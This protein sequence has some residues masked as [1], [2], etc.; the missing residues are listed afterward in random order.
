[1]Q[2]LE[3]SWGGYE[4]QS[5]RSEGWRVGGKSDGGKA[6][7]V[8][9]TQGA[10]ADLVCKDPS[11]SGRLHLPARPF[12]RLTHIA[13]LRLVLDAPRPP[14]NF[15]KEQNNRQ[16]SGGKKSPPS[17]KSQQ[18]SS[19][20]RK[21]KTRETRRFSEEIDSSQNTCKGQKTLIKVMWHAGV[22]KAN[23]VEKQFIAPSI[24]RV[25]GMLVSVLRSCSMAFPWISSFN[26]SEKFKSKA[27][28]TPKPDAR[29]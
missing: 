13:S 10:D 15:G 4:L 6:K 11:R 12:P 19:A 3:Q 27:S 20:E 29:P 26:Q 18:Y 21:Q 2:E 9:A 17:P 23:D 24:S 1:M 16:E 25:L 7:N 14:P 22:A 8:S 28:I 5:Q